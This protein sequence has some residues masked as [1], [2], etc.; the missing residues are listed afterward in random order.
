VKI[1]VGCVVTTTGEKKGTREGL[2]EEL[3]GEH[4]VYPYIRIS[5]PGSC[6]RL[7]SNDYNDPGTCRLSVDLGVSLPKENFIIYLKVDI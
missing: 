7:I 1:E 3:A 5:H 4:K 6:H 2:K